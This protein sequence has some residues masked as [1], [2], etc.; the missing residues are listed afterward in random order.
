MELVAKSPG[1]Q[2]IAED[3]FHILDNKSLLDCKLVNK[4]L[5]SIINRQTFWLK[6]RL[7]KSISEKIE[8]E[9]I[10]HRL[11]TYLENCSRQF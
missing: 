1:L 7:K 10:N 3:I 9:L 11:D 2:H 5:M 8:V 6:R 4:S